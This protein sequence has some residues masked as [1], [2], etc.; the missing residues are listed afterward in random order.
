MLVEI[1]AN[2]EDDRPAEIAEHSAGLEG[3]C[4]PQRT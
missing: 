1:P 3:G 4:T 2:P